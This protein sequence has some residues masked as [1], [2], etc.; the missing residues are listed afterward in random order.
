MRVISRLQDSLNSSIIAQSVF[1]RMNLLIAINM[2]ISGRIAQFKVCA[3][4]MQTK[5]SKPIIQ[6]HR[7]L[8]QS[9]QLSDETTS[10]QQNYDLYIASVQAEQSTYVS[11]QLKGKRSE[12]ADYDQC[13][14]HQLYLLMKYNCG[15]L[16]SHCISVM[17]QFLIMNFN[18]NK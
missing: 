2:C 9:L 16:Y 1:M 10:N 12:M 15:D 14:H 18:K 3:H 13:T 7:N 11:T 8:H 4:D 6:Q 5:Y 17:M